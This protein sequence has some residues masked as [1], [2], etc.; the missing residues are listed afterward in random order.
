MRVEE[1]KGEDASISKPVQ[2]T[3]S[4]TFIAKTYYYY[5]YDEGRDLYF[6]LFVLI[7][8]YSPSAPTQ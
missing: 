8:I 5:L 6:Y 7:C 3:A 1:W 2:H 4:L